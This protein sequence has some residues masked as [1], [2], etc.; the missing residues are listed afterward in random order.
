MRISELL[1]IA[2]EALFKNKVRSFLTMLGIVIGVAAVIVMISIS[3]G[4]EASIRDQYHQPGFEPAICPREFC[5]GWFQNNGT[6]QERV[7][8]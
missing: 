1:R 6:E 2:W 3:A 4:T 7:G 5:P 8:L